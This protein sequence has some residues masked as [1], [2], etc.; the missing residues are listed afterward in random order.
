MTAE[1]M[2]CD[3]CGYPI[4]NGGREAITG[5]HL[6]P[7]IISGK[8]SRHAHLSCYRLNRELLERGLDPRDYAS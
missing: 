3:L 1:R 7:L 4:A 5:L 8:A 2:I 6:T